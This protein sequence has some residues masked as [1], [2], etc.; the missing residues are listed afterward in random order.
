MRE[1]VIASARRQLASLF[2]SWHS[3]ALAKIAGRRPPKRSPRSEAVP[4]YTF[5]PAAAAAPRVSQAMVSAACDRIARAASPPSSSDEPPPSPVRDAN[6]S[7][8]PDFM[9]TPKGRGFTPR[10]DSAMPDDEFVED[11]AALYFVQRPGRQ[12][13]AR[14]SPARRPRPPSD[15][16]DEPIDE[17][18]VHA[19]D[20]LDEQLGRS[21]ELLAKI[22]I[23]LAR[24]ETSPR[25]R[26]PFE[27]TDDPQPAAALELVQTGARPEEDN[28]EEEQKGGVGTAIRGASAPAGGE[29]EDVEGAHGQ[30]MDI[31]VSDGSSTGS[32]VKRLTEGS[33]DGDI[34][35]EI[36]HKY[37]RK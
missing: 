2:R 8:G 19:P 32:D 34:I 27:S 36:A 33:D 1:V 17:Y 25:R 13:E 21:K 3:R 9:F 35:E 28:G 20:G 16:N 29:E 7:D 10:V 37:R 6:S 4:A 26:I 12:P 14:V 31:D 30:F 18:F 5:R 23:A 11:P 15:S 24:E 22:D